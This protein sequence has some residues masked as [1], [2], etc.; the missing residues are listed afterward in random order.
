MKGSRLSSAK[1][2]FGSPESVHADSGF[3]FAN[4][5]SNIAVLMQAS[6]LLPI[7]ADNE[8]MFGNGRRDFR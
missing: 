3:L 1:A 6:I 4:K 5:S 2:G 7:R 8:E